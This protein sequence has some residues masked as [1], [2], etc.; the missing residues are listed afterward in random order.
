M[1]WSQ[2]LGHFG[3]SGPPPDPC[4]RGPAVLVSK[5][6]LALPATA[7]GPHS[8]AE[9]QQGRGTGFCCKLQRSVLLGAPEPLGIQDQPVLSH[10]GVRDCGSASKELHGCAGTRGSSCPPAGQLPSALFCHPN[11]VMLSGQDS[12]RPVAAAHPAVLQAPGEA[13]GAV[14]PTLRAPGRSRGVTKAWEA[15]PSPGCR[16]RHGPAPGSGQ[17][18]RLGR[19]RLPPDFWKINPA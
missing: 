17:C 1:N 18:S 14:E 10:T 3:S 8:I 15:Q 5:V 16:A 13:V 7:L 12:A 11:E 19:E 9:R 4:A 2:T 6:P